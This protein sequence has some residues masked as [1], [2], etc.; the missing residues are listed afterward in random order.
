MTTLDG[1]LPCWAFP[2]RRRSNKMKLLEITNAVGPIN[3]F[4]LAEYLSGFCLVFLVF[5]VRKN[6]GL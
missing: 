1:Q 3:M 4:D 2:F 5:K 6:V